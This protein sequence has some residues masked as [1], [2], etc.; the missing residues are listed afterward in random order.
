MVKIIW[1]FD[2]HIKDT[3]SN[4]EFS[5]VLGSG[6]G[7]VSCTESFSVLCEHVIV[8]TFEH[9]DIDMFQVGF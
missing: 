7:D 9:G 8:A 6:D 4:Y 5:L 2:T 1:K 3:R